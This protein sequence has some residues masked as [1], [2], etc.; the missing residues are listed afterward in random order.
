MNK[1]DNIK[2]ALLLVPVVILSRQLE[3]IPWWSF[4]IP[5]MG[6]G[7][8]IT[9]LKWEVSCFFVG[10]LCG[11]LIWSGMNFYFHLVFEGLIVEKFGIA[12]V[13]LILSSGILGGL[14][15]GL[16][17]YTGKKMVAIKNKQFEL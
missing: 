16:A 11:F 9:L 6:L 2:T 12:S 15:T 14:L 8:T 13:I 7:I 5:V 1:S 4:V 10:F 17:L 3:Y